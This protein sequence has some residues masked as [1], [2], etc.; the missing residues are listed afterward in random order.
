MNDIRDRLAP[1]FAEVL[2]L[3]EVDPDDSFFDLDGDSLAAVELIR[4]I[5]GRFGVTVPISD[6]FAAPTVNGVAALLAT[7]APDES[8]GSV[9]RPDYIPLSPA[10]EGIWIAGML[11]RWA[12]QYNV[13]VVLGTG[14]DVHLPV[15]EDALRDVMRRHEILRTCFP[16]RDGV[17]Y[18][19][20]LDVDV[21][22]TGIRRTTRTVADVAG[23]D[24]DMTAGAP[25]R[26][27]LAVDG[28]VLLLHH[29]A[30]DGAA[31]VTL[32]RDLDLAYGARRRGTAPAWP[33]PAT[34]Y[35]DFAVWQRCS[36]ER[37]GDT[38]TDYWRERLR[39]APPE[40]LLP[41]A[42]PRPS[43]PGGGAATVPLA[44]APS[45]RE[46]VE[47]LT[48][49]ANVTEFLVLQ[50]AFAAALAE[51]GAGTDIVIG[52]PFSGRTRPGTEEAVGLFVNLVAL[53][54]DV[55]GRPSLRDLLAQMRAADPF[56][57]ADVPFAKV[58]EAVAPRRRSAVPPVVQVSFSLD[59]G[60]VTR[61]ALPEIGIR[62][63]LS[64]LTVSKFDL[65]LVLERSTDGSFTGWI[66][67]ATDLYDA[68]AV[69]D[70]RD[71]FTVRLTTSL[72]DPDA[73]IPVGS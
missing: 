40:L 57:Y 15:L 12:G 5:A 43:Q 30:V 10:Q 60:G 45:V 68:A 67:Y 27:V 65:G 73:P 54:T 8:I 53:R 16:E 69:E 23:E 58:V 71:R 59:G 29:L 34:Q 46:Q 3:D 62:A 38:A 51:A 36:L 56:R 50:T 6:F 39:G 37:R 19:D 22:F 33:A 21:A 25:L 52:T 20:I 32:L 42:R 48:R 72:D 4:E 24:F 44:L 28:L 41:S 18:Q 9:T 35:A 55:S 64:P 70:L 7:A 63:D 49:A 26:A 2:L 31:L 17:P 14:E 11:A 61:I 66:E 1:I 13:P 47:A